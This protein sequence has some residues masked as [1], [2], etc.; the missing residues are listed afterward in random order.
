MSK[1]TR[2][3]PPS[4]AKP[5]GET[6][7][8]RQGSVKGAPRA[9]GIFSLSLTS[10]TLLHRSDDSTSS[11]ATSKERQLR[12]DRGTTIIDPVVLIESG[13]EAVIKGVPLPVISR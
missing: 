5:M 1:T 8:R 9:Q 2:R 3:V 11:E 12:A 6:N 7:N 13:V 4:N 10:A